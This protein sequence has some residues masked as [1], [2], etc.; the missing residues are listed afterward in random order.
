[1]ESFKYW[2]VT[3]IAA[4]SLCRYSSL[5][6]VCVT[7]QRPCATLT[8]IYN[9]QSLYA[10]VCVYNQVQ[11]CLRALMTPPRCLESVCP[12]TSSRV[13][14]AHGDGRARPAPSP[15]HDLHS[16]QGSGISRSHRFGEEDMM[17][18]ALLHACNRCKTP[19]LEPS[20]YASTSQLRPPPVRPR[21]ERGRQG[22]RER[23]TQRDT[24]R[25]RETQRDTER[26]REIE[27]KH[28]KENCANSNILAAAESL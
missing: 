26:E 20:T 1:M 27:R 5:G 9:L 7:V 21:A 10:C 22:E 13:P 4:K 12:C 28:N 17:P 24:E 23:E 18:T 25:H 16:F 6:M 19:S 8:L 14:R 11:D 15:S 2:V 3:M